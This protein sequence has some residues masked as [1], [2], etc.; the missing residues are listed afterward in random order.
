M[1]NDFRQAIR[2]IVRNRG[3]AAATVATLAIGMGANA[4]MFTIVREVLL[5]PLPYPDPQRLVRLWEYYDGQRNVI[6]PAN[7]FDWIERSRSFEATAAFV[8]EDVNL[9]ELGDAE[10]IPAARVSPSFFDV[11]RVGPVAGRTFSSGDEP[12]GA[13]IAVVRESFWR[14]RLAG[15]PAAI[16]RTI[17]LDGDAFEIVGI[18]PDLVEQPSRETQVWRVLRVPAIQKVVRGAHYLQALGRLAPG[19]TIAQAHDEL[20]AI[21]ADL[22]RRYPQTNARVGAAVFGLHDEQAR[23]SRRTLLMIFAATGVLLLLACVNVSHLLLARGVSRRDEIAVRAALG[24]SRVRIARQLVIES[25]ALAFLGAAVGILVAMWTTVALRAIVPESLADVTRASVDGTVLAFTVLIATL[26]AL[27]FGLVPALRVSSVPLAQVAGARARTIA[28]RTSGGRVLIVLQVALAILLVVGAGLLLASFSRL[29]A[30]DPGF[31]TSN[32]VVARIALPARAYPDNESRRRFFQ[33]LLARI[34]T[35]G[36]IDTAAAATRV[37]LRSQGP[38][39]TFT[40]DSRP[41]KD[42]NG[43]V[44]QEMSPELI[45]TLRLRII[46]GRALQE[47]DADHHRV[48]LVSRS[49]ARRTWGTDNV[50]GRRLRMG[51]TYL[52]EGMPWLD[53]VGVI[54]DIRQLRLASTGVPQ[55]YLAYGHSDAWS[56]SEVVVRSALPPAVVVRAIRDAVRD[57]D[58]NQPVTSVHTMSDV[59]RQSVARPRFNAVLVGSFAALALALAVVGIYGVLSHAVTERTRE[60]GVRVALG[61]SR[62]DVLRLV[63]R[64]GIS[65]VGIGLIGGLAAAALLTR[66]LEGLLFEIEPLDPATYLAA[67]AVMLLASAAAC[68]LPTLRATRVDPAEAL[69][70]Q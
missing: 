66:A 44:V 20:S 51:P 32:L 8:P 6:A 15:D 14:T 1:L 43:V 26:T 10:R 56:P 63:G 11:L 29:R 65:L 7:Y 37:P 55:V 54:E 38:N 59:V 67:S 62:G 4:A 2:F 41:A 21:G 49:F 27:A 12:S 69:R 25:L 58:R 53:V 42:L 18:V 24:A 48:A 68:L 36:G 57:L 34:K 47:N 19:V 45:A 28:A 46:Y 64:E 31:D 17:R 52:D 35:T 22:A 13:S 16:G 3:F 61:A 9:S 60:I 30:V 40:V 33:Q 5:R 39:M 50:V 23:G 70:A